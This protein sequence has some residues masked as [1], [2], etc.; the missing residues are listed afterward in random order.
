MK[1]YKVPF[2]YTVYGATTIEAE[3][4]EQAEK[5]IYTELADNG[6]DE[7]EYTENDREYLTNVAEEVTK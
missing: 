6:I 3:T 2:S 7:L 5:L 4:P 1:T